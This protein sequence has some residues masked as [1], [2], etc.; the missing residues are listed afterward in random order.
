MGYF[1]CLI[2]GAVIGFMTYAIISQGKA[3]MNKRK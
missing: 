1:I 2:I 3:L